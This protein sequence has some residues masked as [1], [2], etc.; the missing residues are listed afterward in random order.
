M[1]NMYMQMIIRRLVMHIQLQLIALHLGIQLDCSIE[2][3]LAHVL[4]PRRHALLQITDG[5]DIAALDDAQQVQ[6]LQ[7]LTVPVQIRQQ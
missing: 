4:H 7:R 6:R 3:L 2:H 5:P 1:H